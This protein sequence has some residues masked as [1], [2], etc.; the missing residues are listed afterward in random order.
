MTADLICGD[1]NGSGGARCEKQG[2]HSGW[3]SG[4]AEHGGRVAWIEKEKTILDGNTFYD[5][6]GAI[7]L[8]EPVWRSSESERAS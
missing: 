3:H 2:G 1:P 4:I 5:S 8:G 7:D 6:N